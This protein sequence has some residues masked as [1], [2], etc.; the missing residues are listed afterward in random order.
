M[1]D[2]VFLDG[3]DVIQYLKRQNPSKDVQDVVGDI[4]SEYWNNLKPKCE[5]CGK[6]I[7]S[8][9]DSKLCAQCKSKKGGN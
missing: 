7:I 1:K 2:A 6:V 4:V 8:S 3:D 9:L 5:K